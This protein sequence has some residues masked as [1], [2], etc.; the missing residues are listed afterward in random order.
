MTG[1]GVAVG[2]SKRKELEREANFQG[3]GY[4]LHFDCSGGFAQICQHTK[5]FTLSMYNLLYGI[6]TS[7][8]LF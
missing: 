2:R 4:I 7:G 8:K 1:G 5:L 3:D 6:Y